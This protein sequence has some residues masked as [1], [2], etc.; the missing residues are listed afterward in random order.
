MT[1]ET[2]LNGGTGNPQPGS[3]AL[4]PPV[5]GQSLQGAW[6][7]RGPPSPCFLHARCAN[8]PRCRSGEAA[9][10]SRGRDTYFCH[11]HIR[12][13][14]QHVVPWG[15]RGR[16]GPLCQRRG[17]NLTEGPDFQMSR[18][19]CLLSIAALEGGGHCHHLLC[20]LLVQRETGGHAQSDLC[21]GPL[22]GIAH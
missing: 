1:C 13:P 6:P 19:R 21:K 22:P 14:H 5:G 20:L 3:P 4:A 10:S 16:D 2:S 8:Q 18:G 9:G 17:K 15:P 12:P 7:G 11:A